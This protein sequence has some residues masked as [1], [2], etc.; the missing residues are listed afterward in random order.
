MCLEVNMQFDSF[1]PQRLLYKHGSSCFILVGVHSAETQELQFL[2]PVSLERQFNRLQATT[3]VPLDTYLKSVTGG[4]LT[5]LKFDYKKAEIAQNVDPNRI[6]MVTQRLILQHI[7]DGFKEHEW[8]LP[9]LYPTTLQITKPTTLPIAKAVLMLNNANSKQ[10]RGSV[11]ANA[12]V[13]QI[14]KPT[15]TINVEENAGVP[16]IKEPITTSCQRKYHCTSDRRAND[17]ES[18]RRKCQC[19]SSNR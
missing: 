3:Q 16:Q 15:T 18:R 11:G 12:G 1:I 7:Y 14:K 13:R 8:E 17:N 5:T 10:L 9:Y 2:L 6:L 4:T 19:V